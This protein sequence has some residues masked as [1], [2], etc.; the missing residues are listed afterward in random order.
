M[1]PLLDVL[2]IDKLGISHLDS[3]VYRHSGSWKHND[4]SMRFRPIWSNIP[5][6]TAGYV[7]SQLS[8]PGQEQ[9]DWPVLQRATVK[10]SG[11]LK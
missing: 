5:T 6:E 10:V 4:I 2:Y 3:D 8:A 1:F 11:Y 7:L 9:S